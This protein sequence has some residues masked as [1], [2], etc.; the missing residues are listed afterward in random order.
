MVIK[1]V[2][3]LFF[4]FIFGFVPQGWTDSIKSMN[5]TTNPLTTMKMDQNKGAV[6]KRTESKKKTAKSLEKSTLP[7][8]T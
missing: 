1:K 7:I 3:I 2:S 5:N 6:R 4:L 8:S